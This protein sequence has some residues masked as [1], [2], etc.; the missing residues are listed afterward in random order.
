MNEKD[1]GSIFM[2]TPMLYCIIVLG[3]STAIVLLL[4]CLSFLKGGEWNKKY[5]NILM[6]SRIFLQALTILALITFF[7]V[8]N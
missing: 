5:S 8:K 2:S 7:M 6:K 4:G 1:I 3:I